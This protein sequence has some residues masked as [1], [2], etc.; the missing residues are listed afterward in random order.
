M[1]YIVRQKKN[2]NISFTL[3]GSKSIAARAAL[4]GSLSNGQTVLRNT[5]TCRDF[6]VIIAAMNTLGFDTHPEADKVTIN[7]ANGKIPSAGA[8]ISVE[9][10]GTALRLLTAF[11]TL[12]KGEFVIDGMPRLRQRPVKPLSDALNNLGAK[13]T[14]TG[15]GAPVTIEADG[16]SGG[17]T[18]IDCSASSQFLSAL[19]IAA[20][21][22]SRDVKIHVKNLVS[23]PYVDITI[24]LIL[25]FGIQFK[26]VSEDTYEIRGRQQAEAADITIE[27]DAS[28][29]AYFFAAAALCRG[30]ARILNLNPGSMQADMLFLSLL[31]QMGAEVSYGDNHVEVRGTGQ[32][33]GIETDMSDCPDSAPLLAA[34]A[35]FGSFP[36]L[37]K[38]IPHLRHKESDRIAAI[39]QELERCAVT[40]ESGPNW[41]KVFPSEV[42]GATV[43]SHNDH[44]IAMS[45]AVLGL[46]TGDMTIEGAE[47]VEKSF[48]EFFEH[49][50]RI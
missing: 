12:G 19:L 26:T 20:P 41:L 2:F 32:L 37:I 16:L 5:P 10:N 22:S 49:L 23:R 35:P 21:F 44:R 39:Q 48:P 42:R 46:R 36:T 30:K 1:R 11:C 50:E 25:R 8:E 6:S 3:P 15:D 31:K 7:G 13:L 9:D 45:M 28:S 33:T 43:Q 29:A 17:E 38:N 34:I 18:E 24:D 4:L 14:C 40:V 47:C 27:S